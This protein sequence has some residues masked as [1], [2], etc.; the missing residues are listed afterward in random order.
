MTKKELK[1]KLSDDILLWTENGPTGS[2]IDFILDRMESY[3]INLDSKKEKRPIDNYE[4][5]M[6]KLTN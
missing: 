1:Q 3:G 2:V 6:E 5:F 4:A